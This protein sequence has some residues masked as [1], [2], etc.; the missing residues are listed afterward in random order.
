MSTCGDCKHFDSGSCMSVEAASSLFDIY[1]RDTPACEH[2]EPIVVK[3]VDAPAPATAPRP[4]LRPPA[5]SLD[6]LSPETRAKL[7]DPQQC[8]ATYLDRSRGV[9]R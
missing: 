7:R 3:R 6:M 9:D 1:P 8:V 4:A 2:F 5:K